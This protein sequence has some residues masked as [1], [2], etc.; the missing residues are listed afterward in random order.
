MLEAGVAVVGERELTTRCLVV[1]FVAACGAVAEVVVVAQNRGEEGWPV[2][3]GN[4]V[5][6]VI[7]LLV[8]SKRA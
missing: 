5:V 2:F 1:G 8:P 3:G 4:E 7:D 6:P